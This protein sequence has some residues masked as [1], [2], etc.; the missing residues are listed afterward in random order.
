MRGALWYQGESN[1]MGTN[2]DN[3]YRAYAD[4][5]NALVGGW[6]QLWGEGDFPFRS[7]AR[8]AVVSGRIESD[9]HQRRQ[10][11]PGLRGHDERAGRRLAAALGRRRFPVLL[12]ADRAVQIPRRKNF[13]GELAGDAA[14]ILDASITRGAAD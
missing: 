13:A 12:R 9:G 4:M 8:R 2:A 1:L 5:M 6:R 14:G 7:D 3:N 10:Q 11:L